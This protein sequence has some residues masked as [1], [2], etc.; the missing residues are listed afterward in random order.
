MKLDAYSNSYIANVNVSSNGALTI[1]ANS[2]VP[3]TAGAA[4]RMEID[5]SVLRQLLKRSLN[6]LSFKTPTAILYKC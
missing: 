3:K 1:A 2:A 6:R 5:T 4:N